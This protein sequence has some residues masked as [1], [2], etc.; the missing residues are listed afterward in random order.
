VAAISTLSHVGGVNGG[1]AGTAGWEYATGDSDAAIEYVD[2]F[3]R[4]TLVVQHDGG[5]TAASLGGSLDACTVAGLR[6]VFDCV[7]E[8]AGAQV[9]LYLAGLRMLDGE[10]VRELLRLARGLLAR[11]CRVRFDNARGQPLAVLQLL[12]VQETLLRQR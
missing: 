12:G 6:P 3:S 2:P 8:D 10:G 11:G 9:V 4:W 5:K 7:L 1:E